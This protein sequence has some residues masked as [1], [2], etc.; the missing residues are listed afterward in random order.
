[1]NMSDG[2]RKTVADAFLL[3]AASARA[4]KRKSETDTA[5]AILQHVD[6]VETLVRN[7]R[8]ALDGHIGATAVL[9]AARQQARAKTLSSSRPR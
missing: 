1:M 7:I 6:Q 2:Q 9:D 5:E 3:L 8:R 4:G